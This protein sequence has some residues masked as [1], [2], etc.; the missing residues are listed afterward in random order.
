MN[1]PYAVLGVNASASDEEVKR[2]YRDLVKKYHPDNY[3]NNPLADLAE[4]KM[5]EVNEAYDSIVK[6]RTQGGYQ[7]S[8]ARGGGYQAGQNRGYS[9]GQNSRYADPVFNQV[10]QCINQNNLGEAER[11]LRTAQTNSAE[12]YYL[13]GT[14][15]YRKGW[16]DDARQNFYTACSMDPNNLEYRQALNSIG[17]QASRGMYRGGDDLSTLCSTLC[18]LNCL[19]DACT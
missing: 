16:V 7:S 12:W 18:C 6:M 4:A 9:G 14:I 10:R 11:L 1:D 5:K 19:C 2:A 3:A 17:M 8:G 15:S 13:M